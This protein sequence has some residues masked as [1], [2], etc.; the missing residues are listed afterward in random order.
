MNFNTAVAH[1]KATGQKIRH[2]HFTDNEWFVWKNG[3]LRCE[4]G[5][6]M[7]RWYQ[8]EAWQ[9]ENWSIVE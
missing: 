2:M 7:S 1:S 8:C 5:Y 4:I 9:E 3:C 6:D